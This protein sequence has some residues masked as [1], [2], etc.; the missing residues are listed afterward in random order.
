MVAPKD[1]VFYPGG[2]KMNENTFFKMQRDTYFTAKTNVG[3]ILRFT[4]TA[5]FGFSYKFISVR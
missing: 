4:N 2:I 5:Q 3:V 1:F